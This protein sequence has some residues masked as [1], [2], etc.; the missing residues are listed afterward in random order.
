MVTIDME[1]FDYFCRCISWIN[2]DSYIGMR[3]E[4]DGNAHY[5]WIRVRLNQ[6]DVDD[7][8]GLIVKELAWNAT[9]DAPAPIN[10]HIG[11]AQFPALAD[12]GETEPQMICN[13]IF[14]T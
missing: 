4:V 14:K 7:M 6:T 12:V 13:C 8:P 5:G 11:T 2:N 3:F 9:P 10:L 1:W